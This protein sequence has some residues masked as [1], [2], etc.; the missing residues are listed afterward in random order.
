MI[1]TSLLGRKVR[2]GDHEGEIVAVYQGASTLV[3]VI[4]DEHGTL[5]RAHY[6]QVRVLHGCGRGGI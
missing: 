6:D 1:T 5:W 2:Y 4:V 3:V